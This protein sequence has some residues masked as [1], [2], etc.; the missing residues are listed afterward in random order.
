LNHL[1]FL[2]YNSLESSNDS[3]LHS[4][5]PE[6]ASTIIGIIFVNNVTTRF[7]FSAVECRVLSRYSRVS[8]TTGRRHDRSSR[9]AIFFH[10][11]HKRRTYRDSWNNGAPDLRGF[12][13]SAT[14][15]LR[16]SELVSSRGYR[17][18]HYATSSRRISS[19]SLVILSFFNWELLV[20]RSDRHDWARFCLY[21]ILFLIFLFLHCPLARLVKAYISLIFLFLPS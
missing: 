17:I 18:V 21:F 4:S 16:S 12:I 11:Y 2:F 6:F 20:P 14:S 1:L 9:S 5:I 10:G 7:P 15:S 19:P 13:G 8:N 3:S